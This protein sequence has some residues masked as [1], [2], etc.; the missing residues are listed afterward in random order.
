MIKKYIFLAIL[1]IIFSTQIPFTLNAQA[2][3]LPKVPA[4]MEE[5]KS[6]GLRIVTGLPSATLLVW[7]EQAFPIFQS[8]WQLVQKPLKKVGEDAW[9]KVMQTL[10]GELEKRKPNIQ[11]E[12]QEEKEEI[13]L[14]LPKTIDTGK[15][16]WERFKELLE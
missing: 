4:T 13:K 10:R 2:Q 8:M 15:S 9:N 5:A 6:F 7:K 16:F 11:K 3:E 12:F 1:T 14:D